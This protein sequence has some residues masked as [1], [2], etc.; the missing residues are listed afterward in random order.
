[1]MLNKLPGKLYPKV[2]PTLINIVHWDFT[3]NL[4]AGW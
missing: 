2:I 3:R 1:M 4:Y